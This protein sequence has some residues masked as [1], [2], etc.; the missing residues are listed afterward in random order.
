MPCRAPLLLLLAAAV[1]ALSACT[2]GAATG[3]AAGTTD[4]PGDDGQ[5][6]SAACAVVSEA[7]DEATASFSAASPDDPESVISAMQS[8]SEQL[9][10]VSEAVT[11]DEVAA[12]LPPLREAYAA[13]AEAMSAVAEGDVSRMG[14]I[15][16]LG[17]AY[18]E[19]AAGYEELCAAGSP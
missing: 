19:A 11:N 2:G 14:E 7:V 16:E 18:Q 13:T 10:A 12:L 15:A 3:D 17:T 4:A 8:A 1:L 5:S 9:S 6:R